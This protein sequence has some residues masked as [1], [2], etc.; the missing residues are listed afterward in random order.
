MTRIR[1]AWL[2]MLV[3]CM[4]LTVFVSDADAQGR[5]FRRNRVVPA[6]VVNQAPLTQEEAV[7][8]GTEAY[9]YG[10]PLITMEMTR[11]VITN[12]EKPEGTHA[13]MGQLIRL[14]EYPSAA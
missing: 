5:R 2:G 4:T 3:G 12:V 14:R 9:I 11:R 7:K 13:P 8:L 10:Y 1:L 6:D